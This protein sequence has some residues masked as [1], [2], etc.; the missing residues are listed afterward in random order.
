M[1][2]SIVTFANLGR[3]KNLRTTDIVPLVETFAAEKDL[4]Q[5]IC[6]INAGFPFAHMSSAI[7]AW[8]HYPMRVLEKL[9]G[10]TF[11]RHM[12]ERLF[13]FFTACRLVRTDV[14]FLHGSYFMIRTARRAR[15][16]GSITVDISVSAYIPANVALEREELAALGFPEYQGSYSK[17]ASHVLSVDA[18]DYLILMSNFTKQTYLAAGYSEE[19]IFIAHLDIDT[20]RFS[21]MNRTE[22]NINEPFRILYLAFTTPLKGLEYLL[23]AWESLHLPDTELVIVGGFSEMPEELKQDYTGRIQSDP[24]IKWVLGT[25]TPELY[26]RDASVFV[27]PSLTEGFGRVTLEAMACGIPVITTE[28]AQGIVEDGK[29]GFVVPIRNADAIKEKIEYLYYHRAITEQM[30]RQARKAVENK[31]PF[32]EVVFKIYQEILRREGRI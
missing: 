27:F 32:G 4:R 22:K 21:P 23:D 24:H 26:Y 14:T 16:L 3:K 5:V 7:P 19:R 18:L 1:S 10:K 8:L 2:A 12:T 25:H 17:L 30:G 11:P 9:S 6:Q 28:N 15:A 31:K 20:E 29:T 13:D